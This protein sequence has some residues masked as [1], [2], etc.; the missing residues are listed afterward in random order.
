LLILVMGLSI[1]AEHLKSP[2]SAILLIPLPSVALWPALMA[3]SFTLIFK[4]M[5]KGDEIAELLLSLAVLGWAM[6]V[7]IQ[8]F[9]GSRSQKAAFLAINVTV[10]FAIGFLA[11]FLT[12]FAGKSMAW[13]YNVTASRDYPEADMFHQAEILYRHILAHPELIQP[14]TLENY[15]RLRSFRNPSNH[16][17]IIP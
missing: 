2:H 16:T 12:I 13:R 10:Y 17:D 3:T 1:V 4:P 14:N 5:V 15:A 6:D 9:I 8:S 7:L 11:L